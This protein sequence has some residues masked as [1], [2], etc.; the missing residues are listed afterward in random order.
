MKATADMTPVFHIS[1]RHAH[2]V[3]ARRAGAG[4]RS[5]VMARSP[6]P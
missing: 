1:P 5:S 4:G 2:G 3:S 6:C